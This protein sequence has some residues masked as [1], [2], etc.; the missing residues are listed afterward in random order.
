MAVVG[1]VKTLS[2]E[3]ARSGVTVTILAPG[4]H[5]TPAAERV[6]KKRSDSTGISLENAEKE[7]L[8]TIPMNRMG[9]TEDFG[10]LAAWLLS[11]HSSYIS[12]Q[13]ISVDGGA[14][15]GVFG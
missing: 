10:S 6:V 1:Y 13:T 12:G 15:L 11:P 2:Q 3:I 8:D 4:F 7:I 9:A 5:Q 14:V